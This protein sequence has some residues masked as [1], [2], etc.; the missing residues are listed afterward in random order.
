[1][2]GFMS[3]HASRAVSEVSGP[4]RPKPTT[5]NI[6]HSFVRYLS[7]CCAIF[8]WFAIKVQLGREVGGAKD[9]RCQM[10]L[11]WNKNRH[12]FLICIAIIIVMIMSWIIILI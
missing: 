9:E 8:S 5:K 12:S 3:K 10:L 1:M 4:K 7:E 6:T 11:Q 2:L